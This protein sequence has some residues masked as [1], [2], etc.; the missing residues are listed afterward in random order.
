MVLAR[1]VTDESRGAHT[2]ARAIRRKV[3]TD[4]VFVPDSIISRYRAE[5]PAWV[6]TWAMVIFRLIRY[7]RIN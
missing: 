4:G 5:M 1:H 7:S 3:G 2:Q 6:A